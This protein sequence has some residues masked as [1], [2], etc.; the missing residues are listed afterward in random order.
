MK[1]VSLY[2]VVQ[3]PHKFAKFIVLTPRVLYF[4]TSSSLSYFVNLH[5]NSMFVFLFSKSTMEGMLKWTL[6]K[7]RRKRRLD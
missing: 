6:G 3:I 2:I 7:R 4:I 5:K 1:L